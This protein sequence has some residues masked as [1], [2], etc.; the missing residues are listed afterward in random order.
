MTRALVKIVATAATALLAANDCAANRVL[1]G[2][3]DYQ[4]AWMWTYGNPPCKQLPEG[5]NNALSFSGFVD[6]DQAFGESDLFSPTPTYFTIGGGADDTG[7]WTTDA[8]SKLNA[9]LP[10]LK[11]KGYQGVAYDIEICSGTIDASVFED[12]FTATKAAGLEVLVTMSHSAPYGCSNGEAL[13]TD[14]VNSTNIDYLSPQLYSDGTTL[15]FTPN[16][17]F[18]W[19]GFEGAAAKIVPSIPQASDY[20]QVVDYFTKINVDL[21]GYIQWLQ[22]C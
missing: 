8:I 2:N 16:D 12:S 11:S 22:A 4:G 1:R 17:Q 21:S 14:F 20:Q 6:F 10:Q 7:T 18:P 5:T 9:A 13:M 3:G 19:S 15:D